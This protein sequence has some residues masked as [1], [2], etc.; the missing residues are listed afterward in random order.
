MNNWKNVIQIQKFTNQL[1]LAV[2]L[3]AW[4]FSIDYYNMQI[5]LKDVCIDQLYRKYVAGWSMLRSNWLVLQ[6]HC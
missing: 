4:D 5:C 1:F 2:M 3:P 6:F